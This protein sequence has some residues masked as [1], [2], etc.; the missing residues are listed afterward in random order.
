[1]YWTILAKYPADNMTDY[2]T[3]SGDSLN[4]LYMYRTQSRRR[5]KMSKLF[6]VQTKGHIQSC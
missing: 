2:L 4:V 1:M 6:S 3:L 5:R